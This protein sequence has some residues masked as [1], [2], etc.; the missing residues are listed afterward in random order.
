MNP[1]DETEATV[2]MT[3][4]ALDCRAENR[5]SWPPLR[6]A[7]GKLKKGMTVECTRVC[8]NGC[9]VKKVQEFALNGERLS[10]KLV[11]PKDE[12]GEHT[13]LLP[14]SLRT[15]GR[16]T[17]EEA[18]RAVFARVMQAQKARRAKVS[19]AAPFQAPA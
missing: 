12:N 3:D 14:E 10:S 4:E 11:Y 13:Y 17:G 19:P 1:E 8:I 15:G 5:H 9:G 7:V 16:L 18:R 6:K 2:S